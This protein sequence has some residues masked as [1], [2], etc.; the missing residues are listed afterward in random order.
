MEW[1]GQLV[2]QMT[3]S[4]DHGEAT[5]L[6]MPQGTLHSGLSGSPHSSKG[7]QFP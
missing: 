2:F 6:G 7:P 4:Q 1:R 3:L 5:V